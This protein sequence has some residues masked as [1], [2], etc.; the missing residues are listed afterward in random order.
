MPI[1]NLPEDVIYTIIFSFLNHCEC[2]LTEPQIVLVNKRM[3]LKP[4]CA[5]SKLHFGRQKWCSVH[6]P[7]EYNFG[8]YIKKQITLNRTLENVYGVPRRSP[9]P[10]RLFSPDSNFLTYH[11]SNTFYS[12]EGLLYYWNRVL[13]NTEYKVDHLCCRKTGVIF[14]KKPASENCNKILRISG[15]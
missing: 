15:K 13:K 4:T 1:P 3:A 5:A 9:A 11:D 12:P 2:N 8:R 14:S 7:H 6:T 10:D